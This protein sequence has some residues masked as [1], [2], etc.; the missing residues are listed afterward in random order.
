[1]NSDI[2]VLHFNFS[3]SF[4]KLLTVLFLILFRFSFSHY[5]SFSFYTVFRSLFQ[6]LYYIVFAPVLVSILQQQEYF[7]NR[8]GYDSHFSVTPN[9]AGQRWRQSNISLAIAITNLQ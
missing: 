9:Q 6:F 7:D 5:F 2:L 4:Y 1:M 3:F 8:S